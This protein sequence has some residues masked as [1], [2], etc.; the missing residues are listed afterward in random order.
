MAQ[1]ARGDDVL[2]TVMKQ[3][4]E[5]DNVAEAT[6]LQISLP[7]GR[8]DEHPLQRATSENTVSAITGAPRGSRYSQVII[9]SSESGVW[10]SMSTST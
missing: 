2:Q 6:K 8:C 10:Y 4:C 7:Q 9:R 3:F 5:A 1:M